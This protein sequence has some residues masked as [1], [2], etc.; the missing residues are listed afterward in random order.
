MRAP[1]LLSWQVLVLR[2]GHLAG[3]VTPKDVLNRVVAK[4]LDPDVTPVSG[5]MT[6]NPDTVPPEMTIVEALKEVRRKD[7]LTSA[8][9]VQIFT[10]S[11]VAV[12]R[13]VWACLGWY[14]VPAVV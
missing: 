8:A 14:G 13:M 9:C 4:G 6:P 10:Q 5:V 3:I 2:E 12:H 7:V 11:S 1:L